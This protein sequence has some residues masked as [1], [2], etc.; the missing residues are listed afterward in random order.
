MQD[1]KDKKRWYDKDPN[2]IQL[3]LL[4]K[5]MSEDSKEELAENLIKF[6]NLVRKNRNDIENPLSIG[7]NKALGLYKAFNKRRWYDKN[8]SLMSA[9]N[10]L[11]T[12]PVEDC[13]NITKLVI[14]MFDDVQKNTVN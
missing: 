8:Y 2:M 14:G 12:L 13:K 7:K 3:L 5:T 6:I 1:S 10:I 9:M 11:A 4:I